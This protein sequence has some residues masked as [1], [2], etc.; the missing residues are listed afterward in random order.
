MSFY[1]S[2]LEAVPGVVE[3]RARAT[4]VR[5]H[6]ATLPA[7]PGIPLVDPAEEQR[8]L[9]I[10]LFRA[11]VA[12][13]ELPA[14]EELAA[15]IAEIRGFGRMAMHSAREILGRLPE[16]LAHEE[17]QIIKGGVDR[18]LRYLATQL[19]ELL[20]A[21][22]E[23]VDVLGDVRVDNIPPPPEPGTVNMTTATMHGFMP[24]WRRPGTRV[25]RSDATAAQVAAWSSLDRLAAE[26]RDLRAGQTKL[27]RERLGDD[28][29][30]LLKFA[31]EFADIA[32][33]WPD[34]DIAGQRSAEPPPWG[35]ELPHGTAAGP[36]FVAW[37]AA[38]AP[39]GSVWLPSVGEMREAADHARQATSAR[40][41]ARAGTE[42]A[43][44]PYD[45]TA[46]RRQVESMRDWNE[47]ATGTHRLG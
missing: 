27:A 32:E 40:A 19:D 3:I 47:L 38:D 34:W 25:R 21:A 7:A 1:D 26:Y 33:T 2:A 8:L 9:S 44:T 42:A 5:A 28:A 4:A 23:H 22:R 37:W 18:A 12:T 45:H 46:A 43:E 11:Y 16:Q 17:Q 41:R 24:I 10:D 20:N 6:L 35:E 30:Q 15:R 36:D 31:G 29:P 13:G 39:T 14:V